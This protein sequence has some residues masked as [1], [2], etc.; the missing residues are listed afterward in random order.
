M[1]R[2]EGPDGTTLAVRLYERP[3]CHL[4]DEA[5]DNLAEVARTVPLH[6]ER[7]DITSRPDWYERYRER[8]PVL[9]CGGR[10]VGAPLDASRIAAFL[11]GVQP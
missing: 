4:C 2:L 9:A 8:I 6:L 7:C 1:G 5:L 3:G 10:E 11:R